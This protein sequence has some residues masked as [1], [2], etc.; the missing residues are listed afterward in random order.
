MLELLENQRKQLPQQQAQQLRELELEQ[1]LLMLM[2]SYIY[3]SADE[4]DDANYQVAHDMVH[5]IS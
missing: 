2:P 5:E 1:R 4:Y 3:S